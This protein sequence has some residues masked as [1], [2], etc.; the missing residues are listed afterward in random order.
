MVLRALV[1]VVFWLLA[2]TVAAQQPTL[3]FPALGRPTSVPLSSTTCPGAGCH[4]VTVAGFGVAGVQV[5]GTFTATATFKGSVD[6]TNFDDLKQCTPAG[7]STAVSSTTTTGSWQ[8]GVGGYQYLRVV[9]TAYTSGTATVTIFPAPS[10]GG[11]GGGGGSPTDAE[12]WIATADASLP[13]AKVLS[14][15]TALVLNTAGTPS[16]YT[17][18]DCTNQFVRDVGGTGVG[19][20]ATVSLTADVSGLLPVVNAGTGAAPASDDQVLVSDSVSGATWR[21][22]PDCDADNQTLQ[23]DQATN[24][25]SCGD[26]DTGGGGISDGDKGD[27]TVSSAGTVWDI[28][29]G[30]VTTV[31]L[32]GDITAAGEALLD[33]ADAAAQRTTLGLGSI[34]TQAANNVAITGGSI[35]GITDLAIA[36]GG[37]GQSS[38][39]AAFDAL[40]PNTTKGDIIVR[41]GTGN[42]RIPVGTDGQFLRANSGTAS[43]VE[44][45]SGLNTDVLLADLTDNTSAG[46]TL[47]ADISFVPPSDTWV[48]IQCTIMYRSAATGTG[49][50]LGLYVNNLGGTA[51][52]QVVAVNVIIGANAAAGVGG[53]SIYTGHTTASSGVVTSTLTNATA[54]DFIATMDGVVLMHASASDDFI[55]VV[56]NTEVNT[57]TITLREGSWCAAVTFHADV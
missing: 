26:D 1:A 39:T 8:C 25:W 6:G 15:F 43:G 9:L 16:A 31:E 55:S 11:R 56:F 13:S 51:A 27:I 44:W 46:L 29:A 22:L 48:G 7:S 32:G 21:T 41:N 5:T 49:L 38:A 10:A 42:I 57:S 12:Y 45:A 37:T 4:T 34:A 30:V 52:P 54:T 53:A 2:S 3:N 40:A 18:I 23:Y 35:T 17:G 19:T 28:D 47:A 36:D 50:V 14:G 20:C 33:D 24:T